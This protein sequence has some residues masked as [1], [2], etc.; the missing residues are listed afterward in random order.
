MYY[1]LCILFQSADISNKVKRILLSLK[2]LIAGTGLCKAVPK[3]SRQS[4][5]LDYMGM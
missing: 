2:K 1:T 3:S 5:W 4:P